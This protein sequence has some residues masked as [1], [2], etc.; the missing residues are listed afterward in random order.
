[1]PDFSNRL[2]TLLILL[3]TIINSIVFFEIYFRLTEIILPSFVYD[4]IEIGRT[5][6]PNALVNL[7][8]A[9]GFYMGK[10]N[11]YGYP[12]K[13]YPPQKDEKVFR[14]A[15]I[16]DSYVEGFQLFERHHFAR[17]IENEIN[18]NSQRKIEIL[19][20]G[21]GGA[22][23]RG[24]YLRHTKLALNF[25]PD[26]TLYFLKRE[27][28]LKKDAIPVP[29][30]ILTKDSIFFQPIKLNN[31]ASKLR[32][33]FAFVREYSVGNL[34]KEVFET[35]YTGRL[36]QVVFEKLFFL[37]SDN[38][39]MV[40]EKISEN[41]DRFYNYNLKI[42]KQL[43]KLNEAGYKILLIEVEKLPEDYISLI[44]S[45]NI[46]ILPLYSELQNYSKYELN[47]WKASGKLGHWNQ[48]AHK[49]ISKYLSEI[50]INYNF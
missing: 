47:Y 35:I 18:N 24:M 16:G 9:E 38:S 21:T 12:G 25:N 29:E 45:N 8:G 11:K 22:D 42:I 2:K 48:K 49:I 46:E 28:L 41:E 5:H 4:D 23:F 44:K 39:Q 3:L 20:F 7:V 37:V 26:L 30:P 31:T 33:T 15:L 1:M 40:S 27:D 50:L 43:A 17:L 32:E 6:K 13:E 34:F 14:I 10:I 19:N 36:P